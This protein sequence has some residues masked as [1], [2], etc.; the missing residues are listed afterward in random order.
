MK[1]QKLVF[2]FAASL[3]ILSC[4]HGA[5][6]SITIRES[7]DQ[8]SLSAIFP[9]DKTA[10][11]EDYLDREIGK[12]NDFSFRG[13][14]LDAHLTLDGQT[15]FYIKKDRGFVQIKLDKEQSSRD[16]YQKMKSVCEGI[17]DV[18]R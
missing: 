8:L 18:I 2:C 6:T 7:R 4:H 15:R 14:D 11:V 9:R 13:T 17:K 5:D 16:G 1:K 12:E 3:C 10:S